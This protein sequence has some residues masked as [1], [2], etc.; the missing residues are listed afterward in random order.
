MAFRVL[1]AV[2]AYFDLDIDQINVKTAFL[3]G[4][5]DQ[6]VY[7]DILKGSESKATRGIVCKLLKALYVLRQSLRLW[8]ERFSNYLLQKL[9]LARINAD[10]RIFISKAGLN[11]LVISTFV[12]DIKIIAPKRSGHISRVKAE[13]VAAFSMVD[14]GPIS[15][16]LGLKVQRD[17]K[18]HTIKL[19]QPAYI[20]KVLSKFHLNKAHAVATPMKESAIL[21]ARIESEASTA[22]R[23]RYQGIIGFIMFSMV[24]TRPDVAI[25]TSVASCFAKNLGHQHMEAVKTILRYLKGSRN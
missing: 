15:F 9:G 24:E 7:V 11:G 18:N 3:Y 23:E 17:R 14:M 4:L 22:E 5:I 6:L 2:A 20:D 8:Y 21:Q 1:F 19:S 16:Y 13:L 12:D 25:A 10:H